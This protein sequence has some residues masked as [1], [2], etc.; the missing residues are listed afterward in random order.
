[1]SAALMTGV[2][3]PVSSAVDA[4]RLIDESASITAFTTGAPGATR[5]RSNTSS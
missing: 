2:M 3:P 1:M 4:S 5:A